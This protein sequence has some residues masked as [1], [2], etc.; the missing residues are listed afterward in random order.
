MSIEDCSRQRF[1]VWAAVKRNRSVHMAPSDRLCCPLLRCRER[2][3][4]HES[5]LQ[6]LVKC[7]HLS[8]GEYVC[9]EC[10][11][12]ERFN[13]RKCRCCL[14][15]PTKRRR[16]VNMA[17]NFFSNIGHRSRKDDARNV[18]Q[19]EHAMPPPYESL[20]IHT[21]PQPDRPEQPH[22]ELNGREIL[23]LDSRPM[24]PTA[25]LDSI[26]YEP[27]TAPDLESLDMLNP[28]PN[29]TFASIASPLMPCEGL[30]NKDFTMS[31][32]GQACTGN[33]S[34]RPSLAL[35]THIDRYRNVPR[36]KYLS[37]SSSLRST[38]SAQ[39]ISPVTPWSSS[40]GGTGYWTMASSI[41]TALTSPASPS[42]PNGYLSA[43]QVE[44]A[45]INPKDTEKCLNRSD[46]YMLDT[47]PELPGDN[48]CMTQTIPHGLSDPLL[49][50]F[51]PKDNYSWMSSVDTTLSLGTSVNVVFTDD[52][53][54]FEATLPDAPASS[55]ST[56]ALIESTWG[57]LQEH[58]SS[59]LM[60]VA[61][62]PDNPLARQFQNETAATVFSKGLSSLRYM[63][64]GQNP[65]DPLDCLCFVHT[66]Y[67]FSLVIHEDDLMDRCNRL[68]KQALAYSGFLLPAYCAMYSQ[69][70]SAIWQSTSE[71]QSQEQTMLSLNRSSSL[72][73]KGPEYRMNR[74]DAT[75]V[76]PLV[77]V[78][79]NFLDGEL[80]STLSY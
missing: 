80:Y 16:I 17:K 13:D 6:H 75:G 49:F 74:M 2:F 53:H 19:D 21:Q 76:D 39:G 62:I 15:H 14:G 32:S 38:R 46:D 33:G 9:Y 67:A 31:S 56:R 28:M 25:Q 40:S 5:M 61:L 3:E 47:L 22:I 59:S 70:V 27:E 18:D 77:V 24:M 73:G 1:I 12:V 26:N 8:T 54:N 66:V 58:V 55:S 11:K 51:D 68:F 34:R 52:N 42:S 10:M 35:D 43:P 60:K 79:Q 48:P 57:V 65:H 20:H 72:K 45:F 63:L 37:P 36:A 23:E 4:D 69:V 44:H 50:S 64:D 41:G 7:Q 71:D 30:S 78:G 29:P